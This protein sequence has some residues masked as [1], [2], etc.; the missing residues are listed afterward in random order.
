M[1]ADVSKEVLSRL[2][3]L[4]QMCPDMRI[5]QLLAT[6]GLLAEDMTDR[7]FWDIEDEELIAVLERFRQDLARREQSAV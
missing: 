7:S 6:L 2:S 3:V 5:G 4:R 1:N